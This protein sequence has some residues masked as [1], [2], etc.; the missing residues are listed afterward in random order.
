MAVL[1][2]IAVPTALQERAAHES[3]VESGDSTSLWVLS[4]ALVALV[5]FAGGASALSIYRAQARW[6]L[7]DTKLVVAALLSAEAVLLLSA[8]RSRPGWDES[9][10]V[11]SFLVGVWLLSLAAGG[12]WARRRS[13]S[14][15]ERVPI[16][17]PAGAAIVLLLS[18]LLQPLASAALAGRGSPATDRPALILLITIDT[19]RHDVVG[20]RRDG[21]ALTPNLDRLSQEGIAFSRARSPGPWTRSSMSS[22]FTGLSPLVHGVVRPVSTLPDRVTTFS[23]AL[24]EA[25][26]RTVGV[27]T[28]P[29]LMPSSN[30]AQGFDEYLFFPFFEF[31]VLSFGSLLLHV[32]GVPR[33]GS[34]RHL[35]RLAI[36]AIKTR[37]G[38][39]SLLVWL[40]YFD[41]HQPYEPPTEYLPQ[42]LDP[43]VGARFDAWRQV[44]AG[45]LRLDEEEKAWVRRLYEAETRF[46][47]ASL[48]EVLDAVRD[49]GLWDDSLI[50]VTSDHGEEFW[51]H[52]SVEHGHTLY[53]EL[54]RVPLIFKLPRGSRA[55]VSAPGR[56]IDVDVSTESLTPTLLELAGVAG[57]DRIFTSPSLVPF[58]RGEITEELASAPILGSGVLYYGERHSVVVDGLKYI[59]ALTTDERELFSLEEDPLER[60]PRAVD[61]A[62]IAMAKSRLE[63]LRIAHAEIRERLGLTDETSELVGPELEALRS[64]GYVALELGIKGHLKGMSQTPPS[65]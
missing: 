21:M 20:A 7:D 34:T 58:L 45:Q 8:W 35:T 24:Q 44:R 43:G 10:L 42:E 37:R 2:S 4:T 3:L 14:G 13:V 17:V 61:D 6:L 29:H 12:S 26:Y 19:L 59:E 53:E 51:E 11:G 32:L 16:A 55:Q 27:G 54:V 47:D 65:R 52:G 49:Q 23:E 1:V 36:Q 64:L 41:P 39:E 40:H 33:D 30:I 63:E 48:G 31:R 56:R 62:S 38:D 28:N 9:W 22:L 50:V 18:P 46:V 60:A 5:L 57:E 15:K 25:G